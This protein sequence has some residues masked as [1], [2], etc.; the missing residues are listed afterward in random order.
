LAPY[1]TIDFNCKSGEDIIIEERNGDEIKSLF[2][3]KPT[4]LNETKCFNPAFDVT[5]NELITA[6]ITEKG[7]IKQ[8]LKEGLE[9]LYD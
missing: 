2:F 4:A 9:K 3:E 1:S 7:I 8:P 5:D 6:I